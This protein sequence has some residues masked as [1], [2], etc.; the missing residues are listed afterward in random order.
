M[1]EKPGQDRQRVHPKLLP[2]AG[3]VLH[4]QDLP[5][6]QEND[7]EGKVPGSRWAQL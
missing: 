7:S 5:G 1:D 6:H 4:V 3:G 2:N